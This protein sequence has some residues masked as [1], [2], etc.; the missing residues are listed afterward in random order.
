M[1]GTIFNRPSG[2]LQGLQCREG[3]LLT[4]RAHSL[5]L[6]SLLLAQRSEVLPVLLPDVHHKA[7]E[8]GRAQDDRGSHVERFSV[9]RAAVH[10]FR[11]LGHH[12]LVPRARRGREEAPP[13]P[14]PRQREDAGHTNTG[15]PIL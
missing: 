2:A 9:G 5:L 8:R 11:Q 14:R 13:H 15:G 6:P 4:T 1:P 12:A 3:L 10:Q 7:P